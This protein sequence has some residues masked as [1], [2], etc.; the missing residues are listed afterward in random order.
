MEQFMSG[1]CVNLSKNVFRKHPA[2]LDS[3]AEALRRE[4]LE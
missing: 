1:N 4:H 2:T 3:H